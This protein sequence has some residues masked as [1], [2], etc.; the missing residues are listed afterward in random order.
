MENIRIETNS[1]QLDFS[2]S[3]S[4]SGIYS[5]ISDWHVFNRP[6]LAL[7]WRLMLPLEGKR[8]NNA[9]GDKQPN[10]PVCEHG[11]GFVRFTWNGIV[12]EFGGAHDITVTTEC[13]VERDQAVFRMKLQN[14]SQAEIENVFYPYIGDLHRPAGAEWF[15]V[16]RGG[17]WNMYDFEIWPT[18]QNYVGTHSV[19]FPTM[20]QTGDGNPPMYPFILTSDEKGNGLCFSMAERRIEAATWHGEAHP[21]WRSGI[22]QRLYTE[23]FADGKDVFYRFAMG[24]L[25]FVA[26]GTDFETLPMAL[27]AYKGDWAEGSRCYTRV[28][29]TWERRLP[30]PK[31]AEN[32]HSWYQVHINSPEDELRM[33][34]TEL[35]KLGHECVEH[36]I[37]AIQL[38][39]WN[40][41]GQDRGNPTHTPDPRLG[42]FEE[43]KQAI[44]EIQEMG[45]K[46]ILF[47]KF[48]WADESN[49]DF[50]EVYEPLAVKN[51]YGNYDRHPGYQYQTLSQMA[52][53]NTRRLIPMCF[54]SDKYMEICRAEFQKCIDLGADGILFDENH[55]HAGTLCCFDE[56]HGHR[57]GISTY[58]GDERLITMFREMT[59]G[60]EFLYGG[61]ATYNF[62]MDYYDVSYARTWGKGHTAFTRMM[63]PTTNMMTAVTGF[64]DRSMI[65]Q[66]L[67][68]RYIISYEPYNFKGL[69]SDFP[70]TTAYGRKM[71]ALRTELREYF[72]DGAFQ[73]KLGGAVTVAGKAERFTH[74]AV[75]NGTND[76]QGMVICN[77]GEDEAITVTPVLD[78]SAALT[79]FRLVEDDSATTFQGSFTIPPQSAAVVY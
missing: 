41:G 71:D 67:M 79:C 36:G 18:H 8:N 70:L 44:K 13:K 61:E 48:T 59:E 32:P 50:K 19:D 14:H 20:N 55:H 78:S 30:M 42:T 21:G 60:K 45:I 16:S 64:N 27:E 46:L 58:A 40:E 5:K 7:S 31:W 34:F 63:R 62:Q 75:F 35:P 12:S 43:L 1:L 74:Y 54:N 15:R 56:S 72:W 52:D 23:D 33:R 22:D 65:N 29:K 4:L 6:A 51:P 24:H 17:Y 3:G 11:D 9:W 76:K 57:R 39:G 77:Y 73:D 53:V 2:P 26:P 38:V 10:A 68:N 37:D 25:P 69:P 66:C 47:A 49:V 28:S